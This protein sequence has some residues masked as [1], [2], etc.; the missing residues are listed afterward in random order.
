LVVG[1]YGFSLLGILIFSL[2]PLLVVEVA[3][4]I[5]QSEGC[6]LDES[7]V[8]PCLIDGIDW[9]KTLYGMYVQGWLA[10]GTI[11]WGGIFLACWVVVLN[12]HLGLNIL[13]RRRTASQ[14]AQ[15]DERM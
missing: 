10:L 5:A 1:L 2:Y 7:N 13:L 11:A 8:H 6:V 9:G 3:S 15:G 4:Y 14:Q 12:I